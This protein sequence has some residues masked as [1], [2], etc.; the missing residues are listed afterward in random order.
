MNDVPRV[1]VPQFPVTGA[2]SDGRRNTFSNRLVQ[3]G[4]S[5]SNHL[6]VLYLIRPKQGSFSLS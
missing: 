5:G 2:G 1:L 4:F 3:W 6:R